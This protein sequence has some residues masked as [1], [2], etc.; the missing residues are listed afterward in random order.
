MNSDNGRRSNMFE[1]TSFIQ[2]FS[3]EDRWSWE[4]LLKEAISQQWYHEQSYENNH[5]KKHFLPRNSASNIPSKCFFMIVL[6]ALQWRSQAIEIAITFAIE[7]LSSHA[8]CC[9]ETLLTCG[10]I[11]DNFNFEILTFPK[12]TV[13][14]IVNLKLLI[15]VGSTWIPHHFEGKCQTHY[16]RLFIRRQD[17]K[18]YLPKMWTIWFLI[19]NSS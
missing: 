18:I 8:R 7:M 10:K 5:L 1:G 17:S 6:D 19:R 15:G 4:G 12:A 3:G 14:K 16:L 11:D 13:S 2:Q 9:D